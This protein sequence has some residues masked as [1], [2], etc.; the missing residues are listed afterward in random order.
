MSN[1]TVVT[2]VPMV[3]ATL[4]KGQLLALGA[5]F[6]TRAELAAKGIDINSLEYALFFVPDRA[7]EMLNNAGIFLADDEQMLT[8]EHVFP[9]PS[10]EFT[11]VPKKL[12]K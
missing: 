9:A 12:L 1:A 11:I 7:K 10:D 8:P 5:R 2:M 3:P 6:V 4:I